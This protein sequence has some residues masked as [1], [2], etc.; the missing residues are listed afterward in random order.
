MSKKYTEYVQRCRELN[1]EPLP[2]FTPIQVNRGVVK[3]ALIVMAVTVNLIAG[4]LASI[5][6]PK[7]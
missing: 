3:W 7:R 1:V 6:K 2:E 4:V 5:M